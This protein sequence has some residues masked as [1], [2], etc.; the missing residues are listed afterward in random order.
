MELD[1]NKHEMTKEL[2]SNAVKLSSLQQ[3]V[4]DGE[5]LAQQLNKVRKSANV[6]FSCCI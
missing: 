3:Q 1:R 5:S 2:H 6:A 4:T